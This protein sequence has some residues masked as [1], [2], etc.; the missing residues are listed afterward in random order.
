MFKNRPTC[1]ETRTSTT[2]P[3]VLSEVTASTSIPINSELTYVQR[4]KSKSTVGE[5]QCISAFQ[6][7]WNRPKSARCNV[8]MTSSFE[9]STTTPICDTFCT[10]RVVLLLVVIRHRFLNPSLTGQWHGSKKR[11]CLAHTATG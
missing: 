6:P 1:G 3:A 4:V 10:I 8:R 9:P 5:G 11:Q 7:S 2:L